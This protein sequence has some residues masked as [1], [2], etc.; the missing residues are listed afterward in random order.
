MKYTLIDLAGP[1]PGHHRQPA[2]RSAL[3]RGQQA[4]VRNARAGRASHILLKTEGK[5]DAAVKKQA[6]DLLAKVKGGAD[7]AALATKFSEDEVSAAKGGDLDF[8][9]KG[10]MVKE[11]DDVAFKLKPGETSDLVKTQFG[12][13]IIRVTREKGRGAADARRGARADRGH[14]QVGARAERSRSD[15]LGARRQADQAG[16]PGYRGQGPR[17][18]R[19]RVR[20]LRPRG[21]DSSASAW[22][23]RSPIAP[24]S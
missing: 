19:R 10:A 15:C 23:R 8:F 2:G 13:H 21:T 9:A 17:A 5:D 11:F 24:S 6:E 22:R 12:Y 16:G 7:F 4:A 18:D 20:I 14:P 3:L 1:P